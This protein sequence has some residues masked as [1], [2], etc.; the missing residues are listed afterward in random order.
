L[1]NQD[2]EACETAN[3]LILQSLE[4]CDLAHRNNVMYLLE[5]PEDL[6]R[7]LD[8]EL[9]ASIWQRDDV[10]TLYTNTSATTWALFQCDYGSESGLDVALSSKPT[11]LMSTLTAASSEPFS[12][13]PLF[14]GDHRYLGPLPSHCPH[15][16][17]QPLLG[18]DPSSG[19][20][21]TGP[22][23]SYPPAMCDRIARLIIR[24]VLTKRLKEGED[25]ETP[26]TPP[27][28]TAFIT[29][30]TKKTKNKSKV[31][32]SFPPMQPTTTEEAEAHAETSSDDDADT[33]E[34]GTQEV[35]SDEDEDGIRKIKKDERPGG[36]GPPLRTW[37]AGKDCEFHDGFGLTSPNRW[38][39][40]LRGLTDTSEQTQFCA[41]LSELVK[42]HTLKIFPDLK[43]AVFKLA[44]G[45][46]TE[47]PVSEEQLT[48][49]RTDWFNLLPQPRL[50]AE[51]PEYQPFFLHAIGQTLRL[52]G[53]ADDR[54][55]DV[56]SNSY[57]KGVP[58]GV[59]C[60]LPR[61][62]AIFN[63]KTRWRKYDP[64]EECLDMK[65]YKSAVEAEEDLEKQFKEEEALGMM[66][67]VTLA[68]AKQMF[69]GDTLR[70]AAQ[71][72]IKKDDNSYRPIHDATH[73]V[74]VN[75]AIKTR[76]QLSM[77]GPAEAAAAMEISREDYP[78][79]HFSLAADISKAHRRVKHRSEDWGLLAC[80]SKMPKE[81]EG[82][83]I[84][85]NRVGTFG[86]GS[87]AYFWSR[88]AA[89][90]GRLTIKLWFN[91]C[92]WQ[93]IFA[94]DLHINSGGPFKYLNLLTTVVTWL[95]MGTP[96]A[97]RKFRGGI[98]L[99]WCGYYLDYQKFQIGLSESRVRWLTEFISK[100]L[101]DG[102]VLIRAL[103]E[104]LGRMG[105]ASQVL[106]W[107]K[108]FLAPLYAWTARVPE[109]A[110]LK[111]PVTIHCTL[112]FLLEQ[113]TVGKT[114]T[115]CNSPEVSIKQLFRTDAK[116]EEHQITLAGWWCADTLSTKE[117]QWFCIV[118]S[119]SDVPWMFKPGKGSS[120]ASTS[121]E[122]LAVLIALHCFKHLLPKSVRTHT[123]VVLKIGTDNKAAEALGI[124]RS[125][126]KIPLT[127]VMMQLGVTLGMLQMRL[128]IQWR[129]RELNTEADDLTNQRL[130]SFD[131][132]R[133]I[134]VEWSDLPF[135][136]LFKLVS[137][138]K[139]FQEEIQTNRALTSNAEGGSKPK[140]K[141]KRRTYEKTKWG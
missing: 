130:K 12:G 61:T 118:L 17:H 52:M 88:L 91:E 19:T 29:E 28:K 108:P 96:F 119:S 4:G 125:S 36:L 54:I 2:R 24:S 30:S 75:H 64:S 114:M 41:T 100:T 79:V 55:I 46:F 58:V 63:R 53:D 34:A 112:E 47:P 103:T 116:C 10:R 1:Q 57:V 120:W 134:Q 78:G 111:I 18:I 97:W 16:G 98:S 21:R 129:P 62:P 104:A 137:H 107:S 87:I 50:A 122:V 109:G 39:P 60:K 15:S 140:F 70:I 92:I 69:P 110:T 81:G 43:M 135:S 126:T 131:L 80:R 25:D 128:D 44:L 115:P 59:G 127:F 138:T 65:N 84:W 8:D 49:L 32:F 83:V 82:D 11:R 77:P 141:R 42:Q 123:E 38:H 90:L 89:A 68:V 105:F 31:S 74:C 133:K 72:A 22:A 101:K 106:Y 14:D 136:L 102:H 9:P 7:T 51:V 48:A 86:I 5:H 95:M 27:K 3:K 139:S 71:G 40:S 132:D 85:I 26:K 94:D 67:P 66:F 33:K 45:K 37:W 113:Y 73:G 23:A 99:D 76:D 20:F 117:A 13:W 56:S 35:T 124:K 6:G 121:A 93:F